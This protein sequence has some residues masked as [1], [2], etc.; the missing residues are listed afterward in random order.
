L[1]TPA[2][3]PPAY[4]C[5]LPC[6][7]TCE[8]AFRTP[9]G[10]PECALSRRRCREPQTSQGEAPRGAEQCAES[11][12]REHEYASLT[13]GPGTRSPGA[14][15]VGNAT[16]P[17]SRRQRSSVCK[18]GRPLSS[19]CLAPHYQFCRRA[20]ATD[21]PSINPISSWLSALKGDFLMLACIRISPRHQSESNLEIAN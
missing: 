12:G 10:A 9:F 21:R 18:A 5:L 16:G 20:T 4:R 3:L 7:G 15:A 19:G 14:K 11:R 6:P 17:V 13:A 1:P 2:P 8:N